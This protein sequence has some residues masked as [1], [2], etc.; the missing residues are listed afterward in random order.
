MQPTF[1]IILQETWIYHNNKPM[2]VL[3]WNELPTTTHKQEQLCIFLYVSEAW[4]SSKH[5]AHVV[6][7]I[8]FI[9]R[10]TW[11]RF[12][13]RDSKPGG[14]NNPYS[15]TL[16]SPHYNNNKCLFSVSS[17]LYSVLLLLVIVVEMCL[18][19]HSSSLYHTKNNVS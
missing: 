4:Y 15:F 13:W 6:M 12:F 1:I 2:E 14:E 3:P 9:F 19:I 10:T 16:W 8:F 7:L 18:I 5:E 17:I 11:W